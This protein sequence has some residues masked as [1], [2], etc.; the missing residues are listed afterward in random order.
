ME[1]NKKQSAV[2]QVRD[3]LEED[4]YNGVYPPGSLIDEAVFMERFNVSRTPVRTAILQLASRG[5][6]TIVPRSGTYVSKMSARELVA[7]LEVLAEMEGASAKFAARRMSKEQRAELMALH[8]AVR[9]SV[10]EDENIETYQR[11]NEE[12]H[13]HIY[14]CSLNSYL[15]QQILHIRRRTHVYRRGL[16]HQP[17]RIKA[18]YAEHGR[19]IEAIIRGDGEKARDHMLEHISRSG[20]DFLELLSDLA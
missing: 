5:L 11:Y 4:I 1:S 13:G 17:G 3:H 10:Q 12:L 15:T 19:I 6:I 2:E 7:M 9:N 14:E 20:Q 16:F 18:S 8:E